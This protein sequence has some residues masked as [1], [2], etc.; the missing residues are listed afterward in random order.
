M[1]DQSKPEHVQDERASE[2]E[3]QAK[4]QRTV[5][6]DDSPGITLLDGLRIIFGLLLLSSLVSY[7]VTGDSFIW[8]YKA[9]WTRPKALVAKLVR[10]SPCVVISHTEPFLT[11]TTSAV[12]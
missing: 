7:F 8:G 3:P 5:T 9:W 2:P 10:A 11:S 6:K 1:A 4:L 12:P